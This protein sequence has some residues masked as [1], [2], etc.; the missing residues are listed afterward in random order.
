MRTF[1][2]KLLFKLPASILIRWSGKDQIEKG[3]RKLDSGFQY[4][5]KLMDD[6]GVKLDTT[7]PGAE[8]RKEF[9]EGRGLVSLPIPSGIRTTDHIVKS[10]GAEIRVRE[11]APESIGNIYPAVVYFH[12]GGWVVGSIETHEAF[13]GFLAKELNAK[14]FS[15]DYRL[16]PEH[17]FP[18]P[19]TDCEAAFNWVKDNAL[20]L[21][22]NP[23]RVSVGGD[24]A[25]G[26]LSA[27]LC[28]K[29]KQ[30]EPVSYTHLTL[31]TTTSV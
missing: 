24:S 9:E 31:P 6:M 21:G 19:L 7:K 11:Y 5:L 22:I 27:S 18:I 15:V 25:G 23:N 12:G 20:D 14:V 16:A 13:T 26:N 10:N 17:P 1:L 3:Y 4:L 30:E 2:T 8:L 28:I 29:R